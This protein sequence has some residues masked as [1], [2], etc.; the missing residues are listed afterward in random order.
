MYGVRYIQAFLTLS[1]GSSFYLYRAQD[2]TLRDATTA[3]AV[4]SGPYLTGLYTSLIIY[5]TCLSPLCKFP[6]PFGARLTNFW[7]SIHIGTSSHAL[8]KIQDLVKKHGPIVRIGSNDFAIADADFVQPIYGMGAKCAKASWYDGDYPLSPLRTTRIKAVHDR[9]RRIWSP[10]FSEK[11]L[12][13]YEKRL[14]PFADLLVERLRGFGG[15]PV[16][17]AVS[18]PR[19][20]NPNL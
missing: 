4:L 8:F 14:E 13:G 12:R 7:L 6:G 1:I 18:H 10:A 2:K 20:R 16:D 15:E 11:A 17:V 19:V 9:R 5:R 3:V